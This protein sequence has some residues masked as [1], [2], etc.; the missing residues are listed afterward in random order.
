MPRLRKYQRKV[1]LRKWEH[2]EKPY[3]YEIRRMKDGEKFKVIRK[4]PYKQETLDTF[5]TETEAKEYV[6]K[7][8]T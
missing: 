8:L 3:K 6:R 2:K 1:P 7:K 4:T 5:D